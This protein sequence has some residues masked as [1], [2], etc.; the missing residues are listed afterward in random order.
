MLLTIAI[1]ISLAAI[2]VAF[3]LVIYRIITGPT[4]ADRIVALDTMALLGLGFIGTVTVLTGAYAYLDVAIGLALVGF[5][6]TVALARYV[7]FRDLVNIEGK[8]D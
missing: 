2:S 5:L 4:L 8:N 1:Y 3:A 6:A 7:Y